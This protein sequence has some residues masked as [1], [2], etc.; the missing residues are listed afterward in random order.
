MQILDVMDT[1]IAKPK[2][3]LSPYAPRLT[4]IHINPDKIRE[5][6]GKGGEVINK[7][8]AETGVEIDIQ[9]DGTVVIAAVEGEAAKRA[10]DWIKGIVAEPEVGKIYDGKVTKIM[11]FGAF[12]E[13]MPG[14]EG[15]VHISQI[16]NERVEKVTDALKEGQ[17]VKVKLTEIDSQG[18]NNLSI[19][20]TLPK[21]EK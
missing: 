4:T 20:A 10:E 18:R 17:E 14:K 1:A 7:I 21:E 5:V 16:A 6:I 19:K 2:T 3:E 15:L 11:D 13:F 12:V 9:D 8:I